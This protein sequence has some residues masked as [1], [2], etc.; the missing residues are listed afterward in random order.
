VAH[1]TWGIRPQT[2]PIAHFVQAGALLDLAG[3]QLWRLRRDD[4]RR[5]YQEY[6]AHRVHHVVADLILREARAV[7]AGRFGLLVQTGLHHLIR[8]SPTRRYAR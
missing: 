2:D 1:A 6:P 3:L 8:I 5:V 4:V 7:P